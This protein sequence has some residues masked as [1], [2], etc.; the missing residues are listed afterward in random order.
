[1]FNLIILSL[2]NS[3]LSSVTPFLYF[4]KRGIEEEEEGES[5][6]LTTALEWWSKVSSSSVTASRSTSLMESM[7]VGRASTVLRSCKGLPMK[8]LADLRLYCCCTGTLLPIYLS[9]HYNTQLSSSSSSSSSSLS[10]NCEAEKER[11]LVEHT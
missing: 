10:V 6:V 8:E 7:S 5:R 4:K 9:Y 2:K 3:K 11:L 1:M